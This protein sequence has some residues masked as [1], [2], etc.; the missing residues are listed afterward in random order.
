MVFDY[1]PGVPI[2]PSS[3]VFIILALLSTACDIQ[4]ER[5]TVATATP[6]LI[7]ATLPAAP[8][9]ALSETRL[10]PP[11]SPTV[12]PV[13][14]TTST[15]LNVRA[16]PSTAGEVL[17]IIPA[18]TRV[19]IIGKDPGEGWWQI[20]YPQAPDG[21]GWVTGQYVT[22]RTTPEVP[23]IGGG[24]TSPDS[25]N[26][27]VVQQQIN[28][29]SGPGTGFNS[30][31]TLS[32]WDVVQL[33]G[34]DPNGTWLQ[35]DFATGPDGKGW[36]NAAFVQAQGAE[37]LP[38]I[39]EAG[40]VVGTGT[41]TVIPFTPTATL[42]PARED[43]DS[44]QSPS[45]NVVFSSLGTR[46]LQYSSDVSAPAGDQEDWVQFIP[47]TGSVLLEISCK[48]SKVKVD[49]IQDGQRLA[50]AACAAQKL[51]QVKPGDSVNV[52][53][54]VLHESAQNYSSYT[55]RVRSIP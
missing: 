37:H 26:V 53:L 32:Q 50:Q 29:R 19:E 33:T 1:N 27:A 28:V 34:K 36:I 31:G 18:N 45:I 3:I 17:G 30:L 4:V 11:P 6:V 52:H 44:A 8:T 10:P 38:I 35:I 46:D 54:S 49:V 41:P 43:G 48:G 40:L 25:G 47:Y 15:E 42:L 24:E 22:T 55:L 9:A 2:K 20:N 13:E 7:T 51:I 21:K 5:L 14:G 16:E 23:T 39:S 12:A